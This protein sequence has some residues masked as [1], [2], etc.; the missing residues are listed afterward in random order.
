MKQSTVDTVVNLIAVIVAVTDDTPRVLVIGQEA[1]NVDSTP[2]LA[3]PNGPFEPADHPSLES[4]L[5]HWVE[6]QTGLDL[7]YVEQLYT[8]GNRFRDPG[9]ID[10]GPRVVSV[11]YIALAHE[12][13]VGTGNARWHDWYDFLPWEDW[14]CGRPAILDEHIEPALRAWIRGARSDTNRKT[15][16]ERVNVTFSRTPSSDMDAVLALERFEL[17]YEAGLVAEASRD[18]S[19]IADK[20]VAAGAAR[21]DDMGMPLASD[22]RRILATA[23]GRLRGKLAYRPVVFDLL[24]GEFTLLQLQRVVEALSGAQLHK[25]NFRRLVTAADL[26]ESVGRTSTV[27][28][29]RPAEL[30]RFRREVLGEKLTVG[31]A[32]PVMRSRDG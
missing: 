7:Y 1:A 10:G 22:H 3:L 32:R 31:V 26:V 20:Q 14:R 21:F 4:S 28:R 16:Q 2:R 19:A 9:E 6:S 18:S 30:Y 17:L 23:L 27:G 29:G 13:A 11:A 25:Q 15:R 24:P 12:D 8:F 5:R